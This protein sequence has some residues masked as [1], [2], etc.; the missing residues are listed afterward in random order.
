M[1][2]HCV[3]YEKIDMRMLVLKWNLCRF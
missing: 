2:L 3:S 1:K